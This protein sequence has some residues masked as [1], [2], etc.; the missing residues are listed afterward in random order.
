MDKYQDWTKEQLLAHIE[1][2][3]SQTLEN[4][5]TTTRLDKPTKKQR[6]QQRPFDM[7]KYRQRRIAL[8]VA[9]LGWNYAGFA[10]QGDPVNI[11]TVE[12]QIFHAL[13]HCKLIVDREHCDYSRCGR[14]DR[15]VS[16]L[17]QV[18]ILNVRSKQLATTSDSDLLPV[19]DELTFA[20]TLNRALPDDI[21]VLSWAPVPP[22]LN[23]RFDCQSRTYRY[24]F[25][26]DQLDLTLMQQAAH[27]FIGNHDFRNFCKLDPSKNITNYH[28]HVLKCS[29]HPYSLSTSLDTMDSRDMVYLELQGTAFLWHQVRCMMSVLFLVGQQLEAPTIVKD[30]LDTSVYPARPDYPMASDLPL[31]LY[32]C[33]F[34]AITWHDSSCA[35]QRTAA[36]WDQLSYAQHVRALTCDLFLAGT[37]STLEPRAKKVVVLGGGS[38]TLISAYKPLSTRPLCDSDATKKEKY[39]AKKRK[40]VSLEQDK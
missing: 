33:Q 10:S 31:I 7:T 5:S 23:A 18:I 12:D 3:E 26:K 30:L 37:G 9:Y 40:R 34:D 24:L 35:T 19:N 2:L 4:E 28:R 6:K 8:K 29:L 15:G 21:R 39:S 27:D 20:D 36:H 14:T 11:P 1:K 17:G 32:D 16:G 25:R 22:H 13:T 38:S